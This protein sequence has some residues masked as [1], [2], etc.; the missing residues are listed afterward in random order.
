M[1]HEP[2]ILRHSDTKLDRKKQH[3]RSK[4]RDGAR[5]LRP[6]L[7]PPLGECYDSYDDDDDII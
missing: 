2:N 7:H 1:L 4:F 5:L 6:P 3:N